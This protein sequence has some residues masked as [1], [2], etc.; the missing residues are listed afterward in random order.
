MTDYIKKTVAR[1]ILLIFILVTVLQT[2]TYKQ[3]ALAFSVGEE[4]E[5]GEQ[6]LTMVRAGFDLVDEP[7][8]VQ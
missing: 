3:P 5:L 4:R 7:D 2:M 1:L 6:L 8:V